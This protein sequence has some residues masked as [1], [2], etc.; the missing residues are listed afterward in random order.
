[1]SILL[2]KKTTIL[3]QGITGKEGQRA[4]RAMREYHTNVIAGVTP[5]KGGQ[6]IEDYPV[7]NTVAEAKE[8]FP[9][10]D[11]TAIYVPPFAAKQAVMEAITA[12]I[13]LV[14]IMT[15][16]IPVQDTAYFLSAAKK[17]DI[18]IIGP[19]SLG[20]L[21]PN[22]GRIGMIGGPLVD[23]IFT[24]GS[25]GIISRSG[26]MTN[27]ISWQIRQ[28]G[29]GQ[30]SVIHIG[31]DQLV[32]TGYAELLKLFEID[33]ETKAVIIFGEHGGEYE[34]EIVELLKKKQ[35]TKPLAIYIG[36]KF[37]N[38]FPEGMSI[39]HAG[40]LIRR[41]QTAQDKE[42]ALKEVGVLIARDPEELV[43]LIK[44]YA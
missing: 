2:D 19:S 21:I 18:T 40:A 34:F 4:A 30:S 37:A 38:M 43:T 39:G 3:I 33:Y 22:I 17:Q 10:V 25:I 9:S 16:R 12:Q 1:M 6:K 28:A 26:G 15:E 41:G 7:F 36:G 29:L 44:P 20:V 5:G 32:G 8:A 11:A 35:F 23:E 31:G 24:P 13:P 14:N 27:E 42:K